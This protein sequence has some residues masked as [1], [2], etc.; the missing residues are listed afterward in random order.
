MNEKL[1]QSLPYITAV[2]LFFVISLAYF[3]EVMQGK[4]LNQHDKKTWKGGAQEIL[5]YQE[6]T[7]ERSQ[8]TNSMFSGMPAYLVSNHAPN[9]ISKTIYNI[10]DFGHNLRP[11]SFIFMLLIGFW[12]MFLFFEVDPWLSIVGAIAIAF[13]TY[14]FIIIEAGHITKVIALGFMGPIIA[15][16]HYA[17]KKNAIAGTLVMMIFLAMQLLVNHLQITYYTL[18]VVIVYFIFVLVDTIKSK[19]Y[20]QFI[21]SSLIL[22]AGAIIAASTNFSQIITAYDYGQDSIRG[23]SELSFDSENKTN[24]LDKDYATRWSYGHI[25]TLNLFIPNLMGG[26]SQQALSE[27]SEMYKKLKEFQRMDPKMQN[28]KQ[29]IKNMP[30]YWGPQPFTSGPVYIGALIFFF[31]VLGIFL[32]KG[33]LKWWLISVTILSVLLAW[34]ENFAVLTNFFLDYFPGYNKFRTVSMILVIA[35]FSIPVLGILAIKNII[36]GKTETPEILKAVKWSAGIMAGIIL[37]LIINPG[38]LSFENANDARVLP[39]QLISAL[40]SDRAS[41]F[42]ADA[43]RSLAFIVV[44]AASIWLFVKEKIKTTHL[45][46]ILAVAF[47]VDM[48]PVNKRFINSDD[49]VNASIEKRPFKKSPADE[50][51]LQDKELYHK[52]LNLTVSTFNDASTSYFHKSVGGYHGAKLRRYQDLVDFHISDE[53]QTL[54][55]VLQKQVQPSTIDSVLQ[56][57]PILNMLNTKYFILNPQG[58]PLE[59]FQR[60]NNAWFVSEVVTVNDPDE[61][62]SAL[63]NPEKVIEV[64]ELFNKKNDIL[65]QLEKLGRRLQ[66]L[67][68]PEASKTSEYSMLSQKYQKLNEE[69]Y[70]VTAKISTLRNF[71]S[72]KTAIVNKEFKEQIF[73]VKKDSTARIFLTEYKPNVLKYK[74]KV[75]SPQIV[76][77]SDIY[78]EK[79]WNAYIDGKESPH[80]R[81]NYVLRA[82]KIPVGEH[83]IEFKFEP[84]IVKTGNFV[85]LIGS[86]LFV[87]LIFGGIFWE[88]RKTN[89]NS[90]PVS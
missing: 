87:L 71:N 14:F 27:N 21:R 64:K 58:R 20:K 88:Y 49:F 72:R 77:F 11:L 85:S 43:W 67:S 59:N 61:E 23:K 28:P 38:I 50:F 57:L 46:A 82:M 42:R 10:I 44:G 6:E 36:E 90:K 16:M 19:E 74:S 70:V 55:S 63:V 39:E 9:N 32:V 25:E 80:F 37:I 48:W 45:L 54:T 84:Q 18:L 41:I 51:I 15:G 86:V 31:F 73:K 30:T 75:S 35:E 34:G 7:G 66:E 89:L 78:Y 26:A 65:K 69:L 79:G 53:I 52:V 4:K 68:T 56:K 29:L 5:K 12:I 62:I 40:E 17:Y 2:I 83:E 8:W 13:S 33:R 47:L 3:P 1:K 81:A 76:V 60:L 22:V 24:G